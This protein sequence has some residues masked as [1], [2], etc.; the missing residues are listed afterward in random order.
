MI[1]SLSFLLYIYLALVGVFIIMALFSL[2]HLIRFG[3]ITPALIT[4][5]IMFIAVTLAIGGASWLYL[6][7]IDWDTTIQ[8]FPALF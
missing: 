2:Y 6:H 8:L 4:I 5:I 1:L 3:F 7:N